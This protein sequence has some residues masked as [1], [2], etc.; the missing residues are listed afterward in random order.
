MGGGGRGVGLG[1][2]RFLRPPAVLDGSGLVA[3]AVAAAAAR[4]AAKGGAAPS[5]SAVVGFR[6]AGRWLTARLVSGRRPPRHHLGSFDSWGL[7]KWRGSSAP[8]LQRLWRRLSGRRHHG[9]RGCVGWRSWAAWLAGVGSLLE[10]DRARESRPVM[11][12]RVFGFRWGDGREHPTGWGRMADRGHVAGLA[13]T[14]SLASGRATGVCWHLW[15][16]VVATRRCAAAGVAAVIS[17]QTHL[18]HADGLVFPH[19]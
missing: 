19:S 12:S 18:T 15:V 1:C 17:E 8:L 10:G 14:G 6:G 2:S 5:G 16:A 3:A 4:A 13:V 11:G 9:A 7:G